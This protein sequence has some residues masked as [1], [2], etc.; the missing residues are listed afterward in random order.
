MKSSPAIAAKR[1]DPPHRL[2]NAW[3]WKTLVRMLLGV[4]VRDIDCA[5]KIFQR[6]VFDRVQIR[7]VGAMVNTE[8]LGAGEQLRNAHSRNQ[9]EP[10]SRGAPGSHRAQIFG[11]RQSVPRA[12]PPLGPAA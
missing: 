11:H 5:F 10:L 9:G 6:S 1:Q 4:K 8:I 7:A 12:F 3:G 2:I